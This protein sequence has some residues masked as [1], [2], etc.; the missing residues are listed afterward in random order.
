MKMEERAGRR[1]PLCPPTS[2][3]SPQGSGSG[4]LEN[5]TDINH[6]KHKQPMTCEDKQE[7]LQTSWNNDKLE[8]ASVSNCAD[9]SF[10][11][12]DIRSWPRT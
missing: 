3:K 6:R 12:E 7:P 9:V 1:L 11:I 2:L 5:K 4:R 10:T 8:P